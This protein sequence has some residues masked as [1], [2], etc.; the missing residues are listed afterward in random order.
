MVGFKICHRTYRVI[1]E[2]QRTPF[3]IPLMQLPWKS[4]KHRPEGRFI[5]RHILKLYLRLYQ[6]LWNDAL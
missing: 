2:G 4:S 6:F 3:T 1:M 5:L